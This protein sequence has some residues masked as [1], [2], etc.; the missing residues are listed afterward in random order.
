MN[1]MNDLSM[2]TRFSVPHLHECSID[3]TKVVNG[4]IKPD[5]ILTNAIDLW[6]FGV[7]VKT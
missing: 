1:N 5:K 6:V 2:L 3:L 4:K 7:I